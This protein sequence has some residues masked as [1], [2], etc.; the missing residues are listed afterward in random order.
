VSNPSG[1]WPKA[2]L[3]PFAPHRFGTRDQPDFEF[4][5]VS[6]GGP[7][8]STQ[9]LA[10]RAA[11]HPQEVGRLEVAEAFAGPVAAVGDPALRQVGQ[12]HRI[13]SVTEAV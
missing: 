13:G 11:V 5:F 4:E 8:A 1:A 3:A 12:I 2:K 6:S 9:A 10:R 7:A